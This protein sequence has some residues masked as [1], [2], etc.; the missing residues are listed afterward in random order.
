MK[1]GLHVVGA[2]SLM[3]GL[4]SNVSANIYENKQIFSVNYDFHAGDTKSTNTDKYDRT[5]FSYA[6]V[7]AL[8]WGEVIA[9]LHLD[10]Y[11]LTAGGNT[12]HPK[13]YDGA[14]SSIRAI[15]DGHINLTGENGK[16]LNI[17][18]QNFTITNDIVTEN[19]MFVG[20]SYDLEYGGYNIRPQAGLSYFNL[21]DFSPYE[22]VTGSKAEY[23][24]WNGYA[25]GLSVAKQYKF[26]NHPV[27]FNF[28]G[29]YLGGYHDEYIMESFAL[30]DYGYNI[31]L[32]ISIPVYA[33]LNIGLKG[34]KRWNSAGYGKE[35]KFVTV[36]ASYV[37]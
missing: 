33:G 29:T 10:D 20:L 35:G 32:G 15:F 8:S 37:F 25:L 4:C 2:I 21:M 31:E 7:T 28:D 24:D 11:G 16:G 14:Y 13:H 9:V 23:S 19:E 22:S 36:S 27:I 6:N 26:W 5:W 34:S 30:D 3:F 12:E 1:C 18:L 17:W